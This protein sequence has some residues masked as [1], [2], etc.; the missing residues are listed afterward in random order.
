PL[1]RCTHTPTHKRTH[2][3]TGLIDRDI[4]WLTMSETLK[5]Y[6]TNI[7]PF[8]QF[9]NTSDSSNTTFNFPHSFPMKSYLSL[10]LSLSSPITLFLS[11]IPSLSR[12]LLTIPLSLSLSLPLSLSLSP[13]LSLSPSQHGC[14]NFL[15][16]IQPF[17]RTHWFICGSGAYSPVCAYINR[18]RRPE[19]SLL[20]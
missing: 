5:S 20:V 13:A 7:L 6:W 2:T 8:C 15:R 10:P 12:L 18:G 16:V 4:V 1:H 3:H 19:V 14:G 11:I 17:N 9:A